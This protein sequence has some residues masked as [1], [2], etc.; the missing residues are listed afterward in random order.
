MSAVEYVARS[1]ELQPYD[2]THAM[3]LAVLTM[4]QH[5]LRHTDE[6]RKTFDEASQLVTHLRED[7]G[8]KGDHDVL[9]AQILFRE[10]E[11]LLEIKRS[12]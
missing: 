3:N 4:A 7:T 10:A 12:P 1:E 9:I 2:V 6:A 5:H 8:K 11:E